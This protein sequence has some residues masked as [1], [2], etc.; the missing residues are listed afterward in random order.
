MTTIDDEPVEVI[1]SSLLPPAPAAAGGVAAPPA[2][3]DV[4][5]F[6]PRLLMMIFFILLKD[7]GRK[8]GGRPRGKGG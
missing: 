6:S 3:A 8:G 2:D 5:G 7:Y 1:F 4:I